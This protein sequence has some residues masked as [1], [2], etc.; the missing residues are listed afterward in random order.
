MGL[1][2]ILVSSSEPGTI[3]EQWA[4]VC[5]WALSAFRIGRFSMIN[6]STAVAK[7][8]KLFILKSNPQR[9]TIFAANMAARPQTLGSVKS[10]FYTDE[11]LVDVELKWFLKLKSVTSEVPYLD[12][13]LFVTTIRGQM[14]NLNPKWAYGEVDLI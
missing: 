6:F 2:G 11:F 7:V 13:I 9:G 5:C 12:G 3:V 10:H 8:R 14:V 4:C 1:G